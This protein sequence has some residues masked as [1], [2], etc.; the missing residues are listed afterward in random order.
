MA[1]AVVHFEVVGGDGLELQRFYS[2]LFG[3]HIQNMPE[4]GNYGIVDTHAGSG[5]NG[6]IG[7]TPDGTN[8]VTFYIEVAD[9]QAALEKAMQLGG[10]VAMPVMDIPNIV[11]L[12]Q[13]FDPQ[14]NRIGLVRNDE[15]V[16]APG[17]S[18][19]D[20][21]AIDWFEILGPDAKSLHMFYADLFGW[22]IEVAPDATIE[23]GHLEPA[24]KGIGGGIG[25]SPSGTP[26]VTVYAHVDDL[27]SY[28]ERAEKLGGKTALQ[29]MDVGTVAVAQFADP[30]GNVF[31]LYKDIG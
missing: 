30:L 10:R 12:A 24:P 27:N 22:K 23:Y 31:G 16:E 1:N 19:G 5:I 6:G 9:P 17:V 20:N 21:P 26:F 13:F 15:A 2:D 25:A 18:A 11:T 8:L 3:W 29:P 28:L 4:M 7:G 14:G